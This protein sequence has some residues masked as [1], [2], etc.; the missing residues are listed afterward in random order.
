MDLKEKYDKIISDLMQLQEMWFKAGV[1]GI[2]LVSILSNAMLMP[3]TKKQKYECNRIFPE[4]NS[5]CKNAIFLSL[6]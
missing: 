2:D 3:F 1:L 4:P 6:D 5:F